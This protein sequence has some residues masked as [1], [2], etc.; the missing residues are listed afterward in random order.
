MLSLLLDELNGLI[1]EKWEEISMLI[2]WNFTWALFRTMDS[3]LD[4]WHVTPKMDANNTFDF[5]V[6]QNVNDS[7]ISP[8][9][10]NASFLSTLMQPLF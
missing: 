9:L 10:Y 6:T 8:I 1:N 3:E 7:S 5:T 2:C 4:N